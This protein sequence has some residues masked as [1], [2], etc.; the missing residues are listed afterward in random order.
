MEGSLVISIGSLIA[1]VVIGFVANILVSKHHKASGLIDA[2]NMLKTPEHRKNRLELYKAYHDYEE[3][4]DNDT[5]FLNRDEFQEIRADLDVIGILVKSRNIDKK[6]FLHEFGP[7]V[8]MC[9]VCSKPLIEHE[10]ERR[11]F[12]YF[13]E[14]F[15]WLSDEAEKYW[16]RKHVPLST[17]GYDPYEG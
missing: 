1:T 12:K 4:N 10:R 7:M 15:E 17:V 11:K 13:M 6:Q 8:H 14:N 9:W 2:F 16:K 5:D 3:N